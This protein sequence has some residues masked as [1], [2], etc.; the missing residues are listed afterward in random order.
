MR[1]KVFIDRVFILFDTTAAAWPGIHHKVQSTAARS[2]RF[3][4]MLRIVT[5]E[6]DTTS[7]SSTVATPGQLSAATIP[8]A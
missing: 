4:H 1:I 6:Y 7:A 3:G 2:S 5:V 8:K